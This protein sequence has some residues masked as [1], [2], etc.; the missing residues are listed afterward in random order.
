[1]ARSESRGEAMLG[2]K[3]ACSFCGKDASQVAKLVAGAK[4][5]ICDQC[6][7]KASRIM[8]QAGSDVVPLRDEKP[9]G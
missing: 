1:M 3:L 2:K 8:E 4:A 7:A 9:P 6:V 5:Y